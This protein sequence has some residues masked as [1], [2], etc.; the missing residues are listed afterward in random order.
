MLRRLG[1]G[2][3]VLLVAVGAALTLARLWQPESGPF[4][5]TQ[6]RL[7]S[8]VPLA[9][10]AYAAA[11]V[12]AGLLA[13][14]ARAAL[15]LV[16]L[17]AAGLGLHLWWFAPFLT[18][19]TGPAPDGPR[20]RVLTVNAY[21]HDGA[22]GEDL[23]RLAR[24]ADADVVVLQELGGP[25]YEEAVDAGLAEDYPHRSP[26]PDVG[27]SAT[28]IWSRLP[29]RHVEDL[30]DRTGGG[31]VRATVVTADGGL[32]LLGVH[33]APPIWPRPWRADHRALL[34]EV[35]ARRPDVLAGDLNAT[36]DHVQVRRLMATGLRD[37]GD[38][39]GSGW[40][41]TWPSNGIQRFLGLPVPRF[42]AID[43]VLVSP[44]WTVLSVQRLH[45]P[46]SDHT[47]VLAEVVPVR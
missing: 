5:D 44:R 12:G 13:L 42:A 27:D 34:A 10:P 23:V 26:A 36:A 1:W 19:E 35:R 47:A 9:I 41:P 20:V 15:V 29:L 8:F 25:A 33:T 40:A 14:R 3:A 6:V 7:A 2:L 37:A 11:L 17:A 45:V 16:A 24:S 22:T 32:D 46:R 43:H 18:D 30:D 28:M 39:A 31:S 21:I 38:L 4:A